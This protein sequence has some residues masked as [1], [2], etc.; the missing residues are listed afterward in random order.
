MSSLADIHCRYYNEIGELIADLKRGDD[1]ED[2]LSANVD[3]MELLTNPAVR[4]NFGMEVRACSDSR[5]VNGVTCI[6]EFACGAIE[7]P[8]Q[9]STWR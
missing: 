2:E 1:A 4:Q 5:H 3:M 6:T 9:V 7:R 8:P